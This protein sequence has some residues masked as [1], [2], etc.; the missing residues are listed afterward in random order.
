[1]KKTPKTIDLVSKDHGT[2]LGIYELKDGHADDLPAKRENP[3]IKTRPTEFASTKESETM[4]F[5]ME[6]QK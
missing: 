4:L 2:M 1:M 5:V 6:K 3:R